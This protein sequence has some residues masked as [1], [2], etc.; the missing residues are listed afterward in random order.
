MKKVSLLALALLSSMQLGSGHTQEAAPSGD[1]A[2]ETVSVTSLISIVAEKS[3]NAFVVDPRV[4]AE[5]TLIGQDPADVD[6][7]DLLEIL[8]VHGF[9]AIRSRDFVRVVPDA[10]VRSY[11]LPAYSED[12]ADAEFVNRVIQLRNRPAAMVVP[13]LRPLIPQMGHLAA[14]GCSNTLII[15]DTSANVARIADMVASLDVGERYERSC[16]FGRTPP[17]ESTPQRQGEPRRP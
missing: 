14:D 17:R 12:R 1:D 16:D 9:T 8:Q 11:P 10:G 13:I 2:P 15:V 5:V 3:G 4:K 7:E 6:Y